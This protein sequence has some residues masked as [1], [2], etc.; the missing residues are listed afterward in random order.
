MVNS[1]EITRLTPTP[2]ALTASTIAPSGIN[3]MSGEVTASDI[4]PI[5]SGASFEASALEP[6]VM[7]VSKSLPPFLSVTLLGNLTNTP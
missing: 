7:R 5:K 6:K 3:L 4:L 1:Y 2:M